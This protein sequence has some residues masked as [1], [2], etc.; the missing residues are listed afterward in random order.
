MSRWCLSTS[1]CN[2]TDTGPT[3]VLTR[4]STQCPAG[5]G[6]C[7]TDSFYVC[8][9]SQ[10]RQ[11]SCAVYRTAALPVLAGLADIEGVSHSCCNSWCTMCSCM[12]IS[13]LVWWKNFPLPPMFAWL[14]CGSY[15]DNCC[16]LFRLCSHW[17]FLSISTVHW[18]RHASYFKC[19]D[20]LS[21]Q[22]FLNYIM[23]GREMIPLTIM[24]FQ[25][26]SRGVQMEARK[27][28][29]NYY[30]IFSTLNRSGIQII[31]VDG[32]F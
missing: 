19:Y 4:T 31:K 25:G 26:R 13:F 8:Q 11:I 29:C 21:W 18:C 32:I 12:Q 7:V 6:C 1:L 30:V 15:L 3:T 24:D 28:Y 23:K 17:P 14:I 22:Q 2:S 16:L 27:K 5:V 9:S 20:R 10:H